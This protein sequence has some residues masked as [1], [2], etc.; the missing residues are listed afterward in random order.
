MT[1]AGQGD[2]INDPTKVW[3]TTRLRVVLG[4]LWITDIAA[5]NGAACESLSFNPTR[6]APGIECSDDPVLAARGDAYEYSCES[7][8]AAAVR[9]EGIA[10]EVFLQRST[11]FLSALGERLLVAF[12]RRVAPV[13]TPPAGVTR[14]RCRIICRCT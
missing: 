6:L 10:S 2:D 14:R 11:A 3:D 8:V 1:V 7:G 5:D 13:K 9:W 4:E 12:W